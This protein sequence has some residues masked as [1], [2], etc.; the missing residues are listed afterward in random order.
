MKETFHQNGFVVIPGAIEDAF[1][2]QIESS[3]AKLTAGKMNHG[4]VHFIGP[5]LD[6]VSSMHNLSNYIPFY[7]DGFEPLK[8]IVETFWDEP[9]Q[10]TFNS[11]YF[12]KPA[13]HGLETKAH[14]DHA[15]FHLNPPHVV[16][17]WVGLDDSDM[18][19]GGLYYYEGSHRLGFL[20]HE[21]VGNK[22]AS[23][24]IVFSA[25]DD[26]A[27]M[28]Y[29]VRFLKLKRGDAVL[30]SPLVVHGSLANHSNRPRGAIN[31]SFAMNCVRDE[32]NYQR[33]RDQLQHFLV[34]A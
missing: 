29:T 7:Q 4:D 17:C 33:Y 26:L 22:G 2:Q 12:A 32:A 27:L 3:I 31:C 1:L 28:D 19:N 13:F 5:A 14:Q 21:P 11:S 20:H 6:I 25:E 8:T 16:T 18:T 15:Y 9:V 23:Q 10:T 24:A 34:N 30:H